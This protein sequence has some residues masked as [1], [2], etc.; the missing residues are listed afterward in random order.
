MANTES[1][2]YISYMQCIL[3]TMHCRHISLFWVL[4]TQNDL[5]VLLSY[6]N[7][8]CTYDVSLSLGIL[9]SQWTW[10]IIKT[11]FSCISML[12][13]SDCKSLRCILHNVQDACQGRILFD[14]VPRIW[15]RIDIEARHCL[16]NLSR[17]KLGG[18]LLP[19]HLPYILDDTRIICHIVGL[20]I[21]ICH[22]HTHTHTHRGL[23]L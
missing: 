5:L 9:H 12:F 3:C 6:Q 22:T 2:K 17:S 8:L 10:I 7:A 4:S 13:C 15:F 18:C 19:S 20:K 1:I 21:W 14:L 11:D 16:H 23:P